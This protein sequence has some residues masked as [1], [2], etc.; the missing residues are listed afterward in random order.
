MDQKNLKTSTK[1]RVIIAI[2]AILLLGST[3]AAYAGII[4]SGNKSDSGSAE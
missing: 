4:V 3:I 1:Q 2:I